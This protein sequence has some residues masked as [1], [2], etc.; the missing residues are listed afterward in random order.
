M[1]GHDEALE[2]LWRVKAAISRRYGSVH[3]IAEEARR[4]AKAEPLPVAGKQRKPIEGFP[5]GQS[6]GDPDPV[7]A[8]VWRAKD[9]LTKQFGNDV[10]RMAEYVR[11][12]ERQAKAMRAQARHKRSNSVSF[13]TE[14][15]KAAN[16]R[17]GKDS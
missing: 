9:A 10:D 11:R 8:E 2:E 16:K 5:R 7:M 14:T 15:G 6:V 1:V 13:R 4:I 12:K 3:A 17:S